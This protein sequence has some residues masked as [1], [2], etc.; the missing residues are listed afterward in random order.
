MLLTPRRAFKCGMGNQCKVGG[1]WAI[2]GFDEEKLRNFKVTEDKF[3]RWSVGRTILKPS[4]RSQNVQ[5][6]LQASR[7]LL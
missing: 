2:V 7:I 4:L 5:R 6:Y 1:L 3:K